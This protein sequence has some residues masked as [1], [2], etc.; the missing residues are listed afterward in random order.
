MSAA[1]AKAYKTSFINN[2]R[3]LGNKYTLLPF[4]TKVV[5]AEC[6]G[7]ETVADIFAGTGAV[8]SAFTDK[9]LG[10]QKWYNGESRMKIL[11]KA[12]KEDLRVMEAVL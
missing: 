7:I 6:Q 12:S 11:R 1:E 2:R 5:A 9:I 3:Y 8:S 10:E 4:I